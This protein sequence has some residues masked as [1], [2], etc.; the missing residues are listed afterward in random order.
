MAYSIG[1]DIGATK[2]KG[3]IAVNNG[4][5]LIGRK[6]KTRVKRTRKEIL[7]DIINLIDFLKS[8]ADLRRL[9]IKDVGIGIPGVIKKGKLVFGGGTLK[10]FTG[11]NLKNFIQKKQG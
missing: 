11:L 3:V 5:I 4:K 10:K 9:K 1:I 2:I 8:E 7:N 6:I